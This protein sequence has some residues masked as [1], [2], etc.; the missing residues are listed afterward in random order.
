MEDLRQPQSDPDDDEY[1]PAATSAQT[2]KHL[3]NKAFVSTTEAEGG[4]GLTF[5]V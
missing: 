2:S 3:S 4:A 5:T 1:F